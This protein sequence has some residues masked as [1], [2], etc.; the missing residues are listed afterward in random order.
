MFYVYL[1]KSLKDN[2]YYIGQT[3]NINERLMRHNTGKVAS[4]KRKL[5]WKLVKFEEFPTRN[6]ARWRE[7]ELKHSSSKRYNFINGV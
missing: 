7:H 3:K 2:G 6:A 5:P 1:L 4:T